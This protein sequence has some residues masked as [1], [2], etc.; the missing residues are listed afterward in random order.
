MPF[1]G[2]THR[3]CSH[4]SG[5]S[6]LCEG[7]P[8]KI[9]TIGDSGALTWE[10]GPSIDENPY[11][12]QESDQAILGCGVVVGSQSSTSVPHLRSTVCPGG[13]CHELLDGVQART[14]DGIHFADTDGTLLA[15]RIRPTIVKIGRQQTAGV[16]G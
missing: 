15:P 4:P 8:V 10:I 14:S 13:T 3:R 6:V 1:P 11:D 7:L 16:Q 5:G 2:V 9:T 12:S